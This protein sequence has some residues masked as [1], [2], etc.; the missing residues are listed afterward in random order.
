MDAFLG[1][2]DVRNGLLRQCS[3]TQS[4]LPGAYETI[5]EAANWAKRCDVN[6]VG[7]GDD[8]HTSLTDVLADQHGMEMKTER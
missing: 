4:Q 1:Q 2:F 5:L 3:L 6:D 8:L 7:C